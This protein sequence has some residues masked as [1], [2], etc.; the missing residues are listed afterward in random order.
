MAK[1]KEQWRGRTKQLEK[2]IE[3]GERPDLSEVRRRVRRER[4][5]AE[6]LR[7]DNRRGEHGPEQV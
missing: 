3:E 1:L 2:V 5:K 4:A 6:G 7:P